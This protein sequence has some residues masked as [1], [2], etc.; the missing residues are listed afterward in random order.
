METNRPELRPRGVGEM[1]DAAI[2]LFRNNFWTLV[3]ISASV[4]VP[5]GIVQIVATILVGPV[6]LTSFETLDPET[7]D[8][9][10]VLGPLIPIYSALGATSLL[11]F[12]GSILVQ[13]GSI[14]ALAHSMQGE[15]P[16]WRQSLGVGLRRWLPL[17][18]NTLLVTIV[19]ILAFVV[20]FVLMT[21]LAAATGLAGIILLIFIGLPGSVALAVWVFTRWS[22]SP[23]A[24]ITERKGPVQALG[25]SNGL[26]T[27]RFWPVLGAIL[28][29]YLL[30]FVASQI[31]GSVTGVLTLFGAA[32][33]GSFTATPSIVGSVLVSIIA[34]PFLASMITVLYFDLRVRKEGYDLE[35]MAADLAELESDQPARP[36]SSDDDPFGLGRPGDQ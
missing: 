1:V 22:V 31:I 12:L 9:A 25:R 4:L 27:G 24:L 14:T 10:D 3:R 18:A 28:L 23:V 20:P 33:D 34:T 5:I 19:P 13:G 32:S 26:V 8:P 15:E 2:R 35:L 11:S 29:A 16:D 36:S 17:F 6:D 21:V 30:Y 7:A